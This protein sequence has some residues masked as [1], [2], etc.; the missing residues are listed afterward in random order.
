[1]IDIPAIVKCK[2]YLGWHSKGGANS[3]RIEVV[4]SSQVN[5]PV[6]CCNI[7]TKIL[8]LLNTSHQ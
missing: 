8:K 3:F 4:L 1:M 5:V 2:Q 7:E 6:G